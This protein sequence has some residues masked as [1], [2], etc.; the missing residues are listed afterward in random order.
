MMREIWL[1]LEN[2]TIDKKSFVEKR[3]G[4][5]LLPELLKVIVESEKWH[6]LYHKSY[7]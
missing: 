2:N 4:M 6:H 7:I 5:N 3:N 1:L